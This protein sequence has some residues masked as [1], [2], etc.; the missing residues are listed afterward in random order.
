MSTVLTEE[1][2]ETVISLLSGTLV[3]V[4][5]EDT[6]VETAYKHAK[7]TFKHK[8]NDNLT[9]SFWK[10][11]VKPK[12][13]QY[14]LPSEIT[15]VREA[16]TPKSDYSFMG[17]DP[18]A[19]ASFQETFTHGMGGSSSGDYFYTYDLTRQIMDN[20]R[21]YTASEPSYR[22]DR[23]K[24]ALYLMN[25]PRVEQ[26]WLLDVYR[27]ST[28]EEYQENLWIIN[29]TVAECKQILGRAYRKF[30]SLPTPSGE[31]QLDGSDLVQEAQREKEQLLEE[32]E[33]FTDGDADGMG[34]YIL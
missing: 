21:I 5:L 31:S 22:F 33:N 32:I 25:P 28:D 6:D 30:G 14:Q 1:F 4:E 20:N 2:K 9:Q 17:G 27:E 18:F 24:K 8:G 11:S 26:E 16:I 29:W 34:V 13:A 3:D 12:T 7:R 23:R 15:D 10:L 19:M